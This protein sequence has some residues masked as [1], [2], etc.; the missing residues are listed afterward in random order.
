MSYHE[1]LALGITV[2]GIRP[3]SSN[4]AHESSCVNRRFQTAKRGKKVLKWRL[5]I[6]FYGSGGFMS[7]F[8]RKFAFDNNKVYH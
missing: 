7:F 3:F 8:L 1:L 5:D 4:P 6:I 2:I